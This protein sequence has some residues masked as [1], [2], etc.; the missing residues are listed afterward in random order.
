ME[1]ATMS[2]FRSKMKD[3]VKKETPITI[4]NR[5][6]PV[7][8][9]AP[10]EDFESFVSKEA[11]F[12]E[13]MAHLIVN[14]LLPGAPSHIKK[15]QVA[16]LLNFS[17]EKLIQLRLEVGESPISKKLEGKLIKKLGKKIITRLLKRLK[18][19]NAIADAE[20]EGLFEVSEHLSVNQG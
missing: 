20:K 15:A 1:H 4:S 7:G 11:S 10:Y 6:E 13:Q 3:Y 9:Y 18:I 17:E 16:D 2:K 5:D 12:K 14:K 8:I 19:A